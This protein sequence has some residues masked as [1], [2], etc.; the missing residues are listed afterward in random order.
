M[1]RISLMTPRKWAEAFFIQRTRMIACFPQFGIIGLF[2]NRRV[3]RNLKFLNNPIKKRQTT[4]GRSLNVILTEGPNSGEATLG[5]K[6]AEA[7]RTGLYGSGV[8]VAFQVSVPGR[9]PLV[10]RFPGEFSGVQEL[11]AL[12]FPLKFDEDNPLRRVCR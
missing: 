4:G 11:A 5:K 3:L 12:S 6:A 8:E 2:R 9:G 7:L 1:A 10:L